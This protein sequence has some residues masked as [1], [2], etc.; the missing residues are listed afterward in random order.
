MAGMAE[1][2][3]GPGGPSPSD[4]GSDSRSGG[5]PDSGVGRRRATI[6]DVAALAGVSVATVSRVL[7]GNYPTSEAA[8]AKVLRA[9]G[10]LDYVIDGRARAL[11]GSGPRTVAVIVRSLDSPFY[12]AVAQGVEQVRIA[13]AARLDLARHHVV[14]AV[15]VVVGHGVTP[16][17]W[18]AKA[19]PPRSP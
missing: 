2:T 7:A 15:E 12:S 10:E 6:R 5:G 13:D 19:M 16:S 11:A 3:P 1:T 9:V 4:S 18:R 17:G 8:R 14:A